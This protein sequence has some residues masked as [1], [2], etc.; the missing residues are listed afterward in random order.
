MK[1]ILAI[2][3]AL[4]LQ[5]CLTVDRIKKNCDKFTKVCVVE[6]E[7]VTQTVYRDTTIYIDKIIKVPVYVR[8]TLTIRDTVLI[9]DGKAYMQ[10]VR[11]ESGNIW[12]T[13]AVY[14]S[15]LYINIGYKD[16][17]VL[18]PYRDSTVLKQ[19]ETTTI[20]K[21]YIELPPEKFIPKFYKFTF[22]AFFI[23]IGVGLLSIFGKRIVKIILKK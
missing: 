9:R 14:N 18:I 2:F 17:T 23:T 7:T 3:V 1:F 4:L 13:A 5:S 11:K 16:S 8:D 6:N 15:L 21:E 19:A 20:Q 22:W 12:A 10:E